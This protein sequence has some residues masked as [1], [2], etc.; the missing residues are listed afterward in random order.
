MTS[1]LEIVDR[2]RWPIDALDQ[3]A[4]QAMLADLRMELDR[5]GWC[6]LPG[7]LKA[8]A[9][10]D[11]ARQAAMLSASAW[12][13]IGEATPYYG[14]PDP[15]LGDDL[16]AHHPRRRTSPRRMA[17]VAY[18]LFPPSNAIRL[19][20]E[21][22]QMPGFLATLLNL[23]VLHHMACRYQAV[24]LSVMGQGGCQNWH[25]DSASFST[26][27]MLQK[28]EKGGVFECAPGVRGGGDENYDGVTRIMNGDR[29]NVIPVEVDAGT[30]M[31]FRGEQ[32]LH[33][34]SQVGGSRKRLLVIFH[35]DAK[36]GLKGSLA[37]NQALYGPRVEVQD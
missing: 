11:L 22:R 17:Q 31:V 2:T 8:D 13:G 32:A 12:P 9:L 35:Y 1:G 5:H 19:L 7:F 10:V 26:T 37:V 21:S 30:L 25:F 18:D 33:R 34:V 14:K 23:P 16:P 20:Y 28:P 24:N 36:P 6:T 27:L 29:S 3:P 4:G 15:V